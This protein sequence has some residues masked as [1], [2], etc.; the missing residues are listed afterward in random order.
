MPAGGSQPAHSA[1]DGTASNVA[2]L[3]AAA[4][5]LAGRRTGSGAAPPPRA[6]AVDDAG[7]LRAAGGEPDG[8][9][10]AS[11]QTGPAGPAEAAA[12]TGTLQDPAPAAGLPGGFR[13]LTSV[14]SGLM[15]TAKT[16]KYF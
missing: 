16:L 10:C 1:E 8:R 14:T 9:C 3:Q 15:F 12:T 6:P 5:L 4:G 2:G 13:V 11:D 7:R